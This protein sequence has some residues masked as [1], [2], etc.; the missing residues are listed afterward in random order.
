MKKAKKVSKKNL[1]NAGE[2]QRDEKNKKFERDGPVAQ[3][4]RVR[5]N[6]SMTVSQ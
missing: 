3:K 1:A 5:Q 6:N 2:H 4:R